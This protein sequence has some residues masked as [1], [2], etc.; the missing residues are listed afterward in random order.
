MVKEKLSVRYPIVLKLI[1]MITLIV[2][3]SSGIIMSIASFNYSDDSRIRAE[4]NN[5]DMNELQAVQVENYINSL[6]SG[7]FLLF[8][9]M[10]TVRGNALLESVTINNFWL[11]NGHIAAVILPGEMTFY[12]KTFFRA[13]ELETGIVDA[14]FE[15][16]S[17]EIEKS[18]VGSYF[19]FNASLS[20]GFPVA[21]LVIPYAD[22]GTRNSLL[23][24][25][26]TEELQARM[27]SSDL[28][29]TF[30]VN[31]SGDLIIDDDIDQLKLGVNR[32]EHPVVKD[33]L[34]SPRDYKQ[35]KFKGEDGNEYFGSFKKIANFRLG[36]VTV[37]PAEQVTA[38]VKKIVSQNLYLTGIVLLFSI[39]GV[40]F[41]SK[42]ISRPIRSLA[43]ATIKIENGDY[44]TDIKPTTRDELGNLTE[45]FI[46]MSNGLAERERI[47]NTFGKFVNKSVAEAAL[48]GNLKLGGV[49]K[50]AT[51]FFS[52]IRS[53][54]AISESLLPE[55][56]VEF[57][58][59]YMSRM[60][61]C[62]NDA[63]G[64]VDKFIGDAI[65][66]LWGVPLS[67][68][69]LKED[70]MNAVRAT[71][72]MRASLA[73]FNKDRGGKDKPLI[74]IGC[75]INT[76]DAVAGQI[77]SEQRMEYTVIGDAVN[78]ASRIEALNKPLGTDVLLSENTY[79]L[80]KDEIIVEKMPS[81]KVKGKKDE[82][83]IYALINIKVNDGPKTL[84]EVRKMNGVEGSF[85]KN[86]DIENEEIK[87]EILE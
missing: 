68:G 49:K 54:T 85:S 73:E 66:A 37:M 38:V 41:F 43:R 51:I 9:T 27:S 33:M 76:G 62:I 30:V 28:Y 55:E 57:L 21:G 15:I 19:V 86:V 53:F 60:V 47:K 26:S 71:L 6:S 56:V 4:K 72:K 22:F 87:Y 32:G 12:N 84:D 42:T 24:L 65:M 63:D 78:L 50:Q 48:K 44:Q 14:L 83:N 40:Y 59:Q 10:R 2:I 67:S 74:K 36:T 7:I 35:I 1:L 39:L 3:L 77:G 61:K 70:A 69:S 34:L 64:V 82:L 45:S 80:I 5:L 13:N 8:D 18:R 52:D 46:N 81:I 17:D 16:H 29:N 75:G 23:I 58:N 79:Q 20:F 11:R 25:F 31:T